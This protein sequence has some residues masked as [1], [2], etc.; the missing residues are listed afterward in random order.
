MIDITRYKK[1]FFNL[2]NQS[3]TTLAMLFLFVNV[4]L[5]VVFFNQTF[6]N[7]GGN[8]D[9]TAY[10]DFLATTTDFSLSLV[11]NTQAQPYAFLGLLLNKVFHNAT[12]TNRFISLISAVFLLLFLFRYYK[13]QKFT[14]IIQ[15]NPFISNLIVFNVLS[16]VLLVL[17]CHFVGT[18]DMISVAFALPAF[19]LLTEVLFYRKNHSVIIIGLLFA[20]SFTSRPT[21]LISLAAYLLSVV[22]VDRRQL[23]S[24]QLIFAGIFFIGFTA[25]ININPII[26]QGKIVLDIKTI[27]KETGTSWFE[28]NYLMAKKWDAGEIPTTQW[29]SSDDVIQYK[30]EHPDFVFPKN[31]IDIMVNDTGMFTRQ[32]FRMFGMSMYSSFRYT[33]VLFPFLIVFPFLKKKEE[34]LVVNKTVYFTLSFYFISLL[35]FIVSAIKLMEF[36]WMHIAIVFYAFYAINAT[37]TISDN[38]RIV[39]FNT[40]FAI[41]ILFFIL[42]MLKG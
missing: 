21:F 28:M 17:S 3:S 31:H 22:F 4:Y 32:F 6:L 5:Q 27:A 35:I 39:L 9:E 38:K 20:L 14:N 25:L 36:R 33:Y 24:K 18:S 37:K 13:K 8:A 16:S 15:S 42:K 10:R 11:S 40:V 1:V 12:F 30:K 23:F 19:I 7:V 34:D 29:L 41:G 26:N 2:N